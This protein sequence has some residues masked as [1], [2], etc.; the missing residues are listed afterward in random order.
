[1]SRTLATDK[2]KREHLSSASL[3]VSFGEFIKVPAWVTLRE[4]LVFVELI[5]RDRPD[6]ASLEK[7]QCGSSSIIAPFDFVET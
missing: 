6:N 5:S 3:Q 1:M 2:A 7:G 4:L